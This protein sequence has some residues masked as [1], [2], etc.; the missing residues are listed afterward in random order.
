MDSRRIDV[1]GSPLKHITY[2][3]TV[4]KDVSLVL[5]VLHADERVPFE[6]RARLSGCLD[7]L[8]HAL[9]AVQDDE[10]G[11][12]AL[13]ENM[14]AFYEPVEPPATKSWTRMR[15]TL[16]DCTQKL[17]DTYYYTTQEEQGGHDWRVLVFDRGSEHFERRVFTPQ[18]LL[19]RIKHHPDATRAAVLD[20][21]SAWFGETI[22]V[23]WADR[24]NGQADP[25]LWVHAK[26]YLL[27][28]NEPVALVYRID[29]E[30]FDDPEE[31]EA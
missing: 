21:D 6:Q 8:D 18:Q 30:E 2:I 27:G 3:E 4:L 20:F 9:L 22:K 1:M 28:N 17:S 5:Q 16:L 10:I 11:V 23:D 19:E 24:T 26:L 14:Y 29:F 31:R 12:R 25:N 7:E 15:G 13:L